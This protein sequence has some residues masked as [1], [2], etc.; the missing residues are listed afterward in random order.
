MLNRKSTRSLTA[1]KWIYAVYT[2]CTCN[3]KRRGNKTINEYPLPLSLCSAD[4]KE[5]LTAASYLKIGGN[6]SNRLQI[7]LHCRKIG[8]DY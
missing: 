1:D 2:I 3:N 4:V 8:T 5:T 6:I 7:M